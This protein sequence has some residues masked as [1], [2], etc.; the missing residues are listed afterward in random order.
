MVGPGTGPPIPDL[1]SGSDVPVGDSSGLTFLTLILG[2][3]RAISASLNIHLA[4][5]LD[6]DRSSA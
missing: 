2:N 3:L 1:P 6:L 5:S 4:G